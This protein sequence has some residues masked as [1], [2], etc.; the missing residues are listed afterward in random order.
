MNL[1]GLFVLGIAMVA[2]VALSIIFAIVAPI[3]I[4]LGISIPFILILGGVCYVISKVSIKSKTPVIEIQEERISVKPY[5]GYD[6]DYIV[7]FVDGHEEKIYNVNG[8]K[9]AERI[10]RKK[11]TY[12]YTTKIRCTY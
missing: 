12:G 4:M 10:A 3:I 1:N 2:M 8:S 11:Y 7:E 9:H 5:Y 6:L